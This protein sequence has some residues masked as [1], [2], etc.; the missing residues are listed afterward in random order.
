MGGPEGIH[1]CNDLWFEGDH[2][3]FTSILEHLCVG[4]G[5]FNQ[6]ADDICVRH[7]RWVSSNHMDLGFGDVLE[8]LDI[9]LYLQQVIIVKDR[10]YTSPIKGE[11]F[12]YISLGVSI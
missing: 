12:S 5:K 2:R 1:P 10:V 6:L 4:V 9:I 7:D 8:G 11:G 3:G